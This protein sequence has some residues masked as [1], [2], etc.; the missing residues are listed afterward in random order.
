MRM[1]GR[2][3]AGGGKF[4]PFDGEAHHRNVFGYILRHED[5]WTWSFR[6]PLPELSPL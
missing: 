6:A 4:D 3:G 1:P 2:V 5:A